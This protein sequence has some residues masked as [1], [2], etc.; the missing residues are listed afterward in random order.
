MLFG[1]QLQFRWFWSSIIFFLRK[2]LMRY[3][4]KENKI[5]PKTVLR[6]QERIKNRVKQKTTHTQTHESKHTAMHIL[7]AIESVQIPYRRSLQIQSLLCHF[8]FACSIAISSK[9]IVSC[10]SKRVKR[11]KWSIEKTSVISNKSQDFLSQPVEWVFSL[12]LTHT[13]THMRFK[14]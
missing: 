13:H 12:L 11:I 5:M 3:E 1:L 10:S 6:W 4:R 2:K 8:L 9:C 14:Q 7:D